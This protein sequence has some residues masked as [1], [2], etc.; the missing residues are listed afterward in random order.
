MRDNRIQA[1]MSS[2]KVKGML[3]TPGG[4]NKLKGDKHRNGREE[5]YT[6][7]DVCIGTASPYKTNLYVLEPV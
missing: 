4:D 6:V 1:K 7:T 3:S 5:G 2:R